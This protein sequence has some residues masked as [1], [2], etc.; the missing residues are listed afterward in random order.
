MN[1]VYLSIAIVFEVFATSALK[2]TEGFTRLWPSLLTIIGYGFA[3]YFLSLPLRTMPIGV[4]Y[5]VWL[6]VGIVL[7]TL[8][9]WSVFRQMLDLP[10]VLG[11]AMIVGGVLVIN[12]FSKTMAH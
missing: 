7:V 9:G 12:I 8:V 3:F 5:A 1:F 2:Q 10:A 4:V 11:I 6:G